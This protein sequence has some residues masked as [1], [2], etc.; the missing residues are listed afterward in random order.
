[1]IHLHL[2]SNGLSRTSQLLQEESSVGLPGS[3]VNLS[4]LTN[5]GRWGDV[6]TSLNRL[7][8]EVYDAIPATLIA[9]VKEMTILELSEADPNLSMQ[10]YDRLIDDD[11]QP[12]DG[13]DDKD[14]GKKSIFTTKS[15]NRMRDS[16]TSSVKF[17]DSGETRDQRRA[18][19]GEELEIYVKT[20]QDDKL[21]MLLRQ[22]LLW[23]VHTNT[24]PK[25]L[26]TKVRRLLV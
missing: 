2:L 4:V 20:A 14:S 22:S 16:F 21:L 3:T 7:D 18:R 25:A 5:V 17:S 8:A 10:I 26:E 9:E 11:L 6:L 19:I 1:M 13:K 23:Q 15:I 12:I 24:L